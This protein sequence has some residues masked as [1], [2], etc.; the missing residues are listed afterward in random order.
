MNFENKLILLLLNEGKILDKFKN[1]FSK[2]KKEPKKFED[3]FGEPWKK[4]SPPSKE[5]EAKN[6]EKWKVNRRGGDN[7]TGEDEFYGSI[8]G[9]RDEVS[10]PGWGHTK[11]G[12]KKSI[13]VG[14][15]AAAMKKAQARGDIPKKMNI[16]ALMWS[17]KNKGDKPHYKPGKRGVLKKK[18]KN[19]QA[20]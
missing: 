17:M 3:V 19:S 16:F 4:E 10:P 15:T 8:R 18:F 14:G 11:T 6:K 12:G 20:R 9:R 7:P 2:K 1:F 5:E 13:K